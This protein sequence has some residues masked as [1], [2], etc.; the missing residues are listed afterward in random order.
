M[1]QQCP[2]NSV[3]MPCIPEQFTHPVAL[4]WSDEPAVLRAKVRLE[5]SNN[6]GDTRTLGCRVTVNTCMVAV[7]TVMCVHARA[8]AINELYKMTHS[9]QEAV[10]TRHFNLPETREEKTSWE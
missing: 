7:S 2:V 3:D 6:E 10:L 4:I 9:I 8:S 1:V 5:S